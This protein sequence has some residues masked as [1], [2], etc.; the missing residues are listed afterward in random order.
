MLIIKPFIFNTFPEILFG[1]STKIGPDAESPFYFNLSYSV[2]DEKGKVDQNRKMFFEKVGLSTNSVSFQKQVHEDFIQEVNEAGN[3]GESD[4]L[5]TTSKNLGLAISSADCPAIFIYDPVQKAIAAVHSGWRGTEKKIVQKTIIKMKNEFNS[6]A[7][8][9]VCY[10]SPS[11][12]QVNYQVGKD[13]AEKFDS[14]FVMFKDNKCFLDVAGA[15]Y[16]MLI[17]EGVKKINIQLSKLCSF[18][19]ENI[20]HSYRRDGQKSGRALGVIAVKDDR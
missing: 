17:D 11:I 20:L 4:G 2:S 15:N 14:E 12:S 7:S 13:V 8:D 18:E 10:I 5:I 1:F 9:M 6:N 3:C 16:K 19:Y